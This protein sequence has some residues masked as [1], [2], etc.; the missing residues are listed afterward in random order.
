MLCNRGIYHKGWTA[1][2][3]HGSV[4][5]K[6]IGVQPPLSEDVWELYDTNK[7]WSQARNLATQMP[8]MLAELRRLFDVEAAK[9]NVFP[10]DDRRAER[11][12]PD[13]AGRPS[14]VHGDTQLLFP[15][16]RRLQ[17][18]AVINTKN[19]SHS[20]T[21]EVVVPDSGAHGVIVAQ[22]GSMGGW[23]LHVHERKLKYVYNFLGLMSFEVAAASPLPSGK[24]QIRMEFAYDGGGRGKGA[25]IALYVDGAKVGQGRVERSHALFFSQDETLDVGSD[26]GDPVSKDYGPRG[27]AF[28]GKIDWVQIDIDAAAKDADHMIGA[29]ERFQLMMMRQEAM[30]VLLLNSYIALLALFVWLRFIPFNLFWKLSPVI[31]LLALLVGLFIPMGWGA[32]SG[33]AVVLRNSVEIIPGVA[34]SVVDVPIE[35]NKPIKAGEV[36][37]KIDPAT[38]QAAFDQYSAQLQRDQALLAKDQA[39]L[40]RYQTLV[41]QNSIAR[42]QAEDQK[43]IV[44]QDQANTRL[45]QALIDGAQHNLD[46][47]V[48][49]APT[50]GYVTNLAL[51][52]GA[53]VNGQS[54]VMA[55][56]DTADTIFGVQIPQ[57]YAR[58]VA[59]GQPVEVTFKFFPGLVYTARVEAVLQAI[60]AGQAQVGG[61]Q[62]R[63]NT[64]EIEPG[65]L[66]RPANLEIARMVFQIEGDRVATLQTQ[67]PEW[68]RALI[69]PILEFSVRDDF[70]GSGHD[71][72]GF[73]GVGVRVVARMQ[74]FLRFAAFLSL[75]SPLRRSREA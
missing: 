11:A 12:N 46:N 15:G 42:Q 29:E 58:Y 73:V 24:R 70:T 47:T 45:D 16:M 27:N 43:Y 17:E 51:R 35:P 59:V 49:T 37:F 50:D 68:L 19:K 9:Y 67:R 52:K 30:I 75:A 8:E 40:Q 1:V 25:A 4:P 34:G 7:D 14:V 41:A 6:V 21:A 32:P 20:V 56:I 38:Y 69:R 71:D 28:T 65:P 33:P 64:R 54:P 23:T 74:D 31:V 2:T 13:I 18:N 39:N 63:G 66:R 62:R 57:I 55:F 53:R 5:W 48:V 60:A 36:L 10:L 3:R 22:G 72:R 26:M 61:L 44:D